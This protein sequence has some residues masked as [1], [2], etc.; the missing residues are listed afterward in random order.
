MGLCSP[1]VPCA[2]CAKPIG[3]GCEVLGFPDLVPM[4][5]EFGEFYDGCAHQ[6]C[7][8]YWPRKAEFV[9]Y[10]NGLVDVSKLSPSWR[11]LI[12]PSGLVTYQRNFDNQE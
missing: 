6:D 9:D 5:S 8:T 4:F 1:V 11:L 3:T 10:F 12:L 2:I 7:M